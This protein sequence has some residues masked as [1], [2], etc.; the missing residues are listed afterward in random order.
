MF[1]AFGLGG[2]F[3]GE[4]DTVVVERLVEFAQAVR[5]Y[6][7]QRGQLR[8][9]ETAQLS[10]GLHVMGRQDFAG[11][12]RQ[13]QVLQL[14]PQVDFGEAIVGSEWGRAG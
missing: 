8:C 10:Q 13:Q 7:R 11:L 5:S 14:Q 1:L 9:R 2:G 12:G 6:S 3:R 4:G